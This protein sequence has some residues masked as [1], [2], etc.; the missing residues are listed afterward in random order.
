MSVSF[1]SAKCSFQTDHI[2]VLPVANHVRCRFLDTWIHNVLPFHVF[3]L[4]EPL[5]LTGALPGVCSVF[6]QDLPFEDYPTAPSGPRDFA[7]LPSTY[8]L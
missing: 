7:W 2:I 6:P 5:A 8:W 1:C 4:N 3:N